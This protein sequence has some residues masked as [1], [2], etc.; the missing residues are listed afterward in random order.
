MPII[1]AFAKMPFLM[2]TVKQNA[3]LA[4]QVAKHVKQLLH[5][6]LLVQRDIIIYLNPLLALNATFPV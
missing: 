3:V 5:I 2:L 6:A 4:I 1:N